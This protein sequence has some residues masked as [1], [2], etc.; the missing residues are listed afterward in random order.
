[1][2]KAR[3]LKTK[4][5]V[6]ILLS[7]YPDKFSTDFEENKKVVHEVTTITSKSLCNKIAGYIAKFLI[8]NENVKRA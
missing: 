4:R 2:G 7:K 6:K 3:A 5:I 8:A 1:M